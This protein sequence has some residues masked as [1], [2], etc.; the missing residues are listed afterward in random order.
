MAHGLNCI[1][2]TRKLQ[3][4]LINDLMK[5][6][7]QVFVKVPCRVQFFRETLPDV[8]LPPEFN[9]ALVF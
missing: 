3:I 8:A 7:I 5:S 9:Q 1:A 6:G 2:E 4:P